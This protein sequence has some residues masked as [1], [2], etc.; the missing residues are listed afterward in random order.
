MLPSQYGD[1]PRS[2][3]T[4]GQAELVKLLIARGFGKGRAEFAGE[5]WVA[6]ERS[7]AD[8]AAADQIPDSLR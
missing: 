5:W 2:W 7:S 3:K 1:Q 4:L 8:A 6:R